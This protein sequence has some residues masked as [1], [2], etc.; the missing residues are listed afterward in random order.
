M[1]EV[2]CFTLPMNR[3]L[4]KRL[5]SER[6][7]AGASSDRIM[8]PPPGS[9]LENELYF[10]VMCKEASRNMGCL[11]SYTRQIA[12]L[13]QDTEHSMFSG[14]VPVLVC[15]GSVVKQWKS[16]GLRTSVKY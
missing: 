12:H 6:W 8:K 16:F 13:T 5:A 11:Y 10:Q 2:T 14:G 4:R 3:R 7:H 15:A 9:T 1:T